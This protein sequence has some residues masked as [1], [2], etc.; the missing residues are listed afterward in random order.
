MVID[1]KKSA[2]YKITVKGEIIDGWPERLWGL[3]V[4]KEKEKHHISSLV[5]QIADQSALSAILNM[6][7]DKHMTVISVNMLSEVDDK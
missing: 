6:L 5:G 4:H 7:Y 3:Q 1:F 2:I